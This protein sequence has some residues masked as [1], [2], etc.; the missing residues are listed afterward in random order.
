M[1]ELFRNRIQDLVR[2]QQKRDMLLFTGF[3]TPEEQA[4]AASLTRHHPN[5]RF[6]GGYPGAERRVLA[7]LPSYMED[8][9][10]A[11]EEVMGVLLI[12]TPFSHGLTH[13][14]YLGALL[15]LGVKRECIGDILVGDQQAQVIVL[16][17]MLPF[18]LEN[19]LQ[20]GRFAAQTEEL[21]L[22]D[23]RNTPQQTKPIRCT[24]PQMRLDCIAAAAFSLSRSKMSQFI[25]QGVVNLN[26]LPCLKQDHTVEEGDTISCRGLGKAKVTAIGGRSRKDRLWVELERYL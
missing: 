14:D 9:A 17:R 21:P 18:F 13:R 19:V 12:R 3:L 16:A 8:T 1:D 26:H 23:I 22:A 2:Q 7:L 11:E 6:L 20:I 4:A 15:G 24:V 5:A 10:M 25:A